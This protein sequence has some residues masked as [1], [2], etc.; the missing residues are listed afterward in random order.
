M[1]GDGTLDDQRGTG[2]WS[3]P[4]GASGHP[5]PVH[6]ADA[7][8]RCLPRLAAGPRAPEAVQEADADQELAAPAG[9]DGGAG[10]D[11]AGPGAAAVV[12]AD[13]PGRRVGADRAGAGL[14][15]QP[16]DGLQGEQQDPA[17]RGQGAGPGLAQ[18]DSRFEHGLPGQ[19]GRSR[20]RRWGCRRR[21]PASGSTT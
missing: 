5:P 1:T 16:V 14:R 17:R 7:Q 4:G 6:E 15:Y 13:A 9:A 19:F 18:P 21:R 2:R 12:F 8:A 11:G 3:R 20:A 10:A